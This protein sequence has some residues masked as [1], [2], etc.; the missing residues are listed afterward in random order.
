LTPGAHRGRS[1]RSTLLAVVLRGAAAL[2]PA[3]QLHL[4]E[5][6]SFEKHTAY[7]ALFLARHDRDVAGRD[8]GGLRA[9]RVCRIGAR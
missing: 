1:A 7:S 2:I 5:A 3:G 9:R 8:V 4:H 6:V